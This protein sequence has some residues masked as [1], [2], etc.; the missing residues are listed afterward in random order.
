MIVNRSYTVG[1]AELLAAGGFVPA[2]EGLFDSE[3]LRWYISDADPERVLVEATECD[4]IVAAPLPAAVPPAPGGIG[5]VISLIP[6]GVG[7]SIGGYAGDAAPAT[8]LLAAAADYVVTNPNAVNA[9]NFISIGE[10]VLYTEGACIDL[11]VRGMVNLYQPYANRVGIIVERASR[12]A[13]DEVF[14]IVN[15]VRAVYG[16]DIVDVVVTDQPIGTRS[17]RN[18]SGGYTGQIDRPDV[19]L[20]AAQQLLD[21][22][23]TAIAVTTDVQELSTGSYSDHFQGRHPN[24][25]GGAEA[26]LS[27]LIVRTFST[28]AAHAPLVNFKD[29]ALPEGVVDARGAGEF[30]SANGLASVL[31]GLRRA[32][33]ITGAARCRIARTVGLDD[34]L[35]VVAP[36]SA[37]GGIPVLEAAHRGIPV[38]GVA[39]N[40]TI[41]DVTA[42]RLQLD[43][44]TGVRSYA[45]AAGVILALRHGISLES[46]QRPLPSRA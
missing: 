16:I 35:A 39:D 27:H 14:N 10:R 28:P 20:K 46:L 3:P 11:F 37:L 22:G 29:V 9:S 2:I 26:V 24:P 31:I 44:V 33:Q 23:A 18:P 12:T 41:I 25:V 32:P 5:V 13:L 42:E 40:E 36:A 1:R 17:V 15:T 34:V 6:T 19:L 30:V 21:A 38:I 43:G 4:G 45:E 8:A 7:C